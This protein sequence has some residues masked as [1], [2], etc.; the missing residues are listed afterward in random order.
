ME[1]LVSVIIPMYNIEK[2]IKE[3]IESIINSSYKHLEI[4][5]VDDF[6][7]DN[8][9]EVVK[10]FVK[11]DSRVVFL[12]SLKNSGVCKT[13]NR[14][15]QKANGK[16][17]VFVDGDD[18]I[19]E[20]WIENLVKS[21]EKE[22]SDVVIGKAKN[23]RDG[24][25]EEYQIRDLKKSGYLKFE[26]IRLNKN[27]VIWNKIYNLDFLKNN[28]LLFSEERLSYGEDLEFVYRV[29]SCANSIYYT[30]AGEY[31]YRLGRP[32][33]LSQDIYSK[34]RVEN[35]TLLLKKLVSFTKSSKRCN[36]NILKKIAKDIMIEHFE[37]PEIQVDLRLVRGVGYFIPE[38]CW[39]NTLRKEIKRRIKLG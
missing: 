2:Y 20:F 12:E 24:K 19:S 21:I 18:F 6:S 1:S 29:L 32:L 8:G 35:L 26:N 7:T 28:K 23:Y 4:I 13:R 25:I 16:Y 30:E 38:I 33:S 27:G 9:K 11:K 17:V 37:N 31:Y 15:L 39:F 22:K 5:V 34:K 3:C 36:K 10:E 14:G